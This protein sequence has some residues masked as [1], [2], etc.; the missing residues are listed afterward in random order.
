MDEIQVLTLNA[1]RKKKYYVSA[2]QYI[3]KIKS[4]YNLAFSKTL[5]VVLYQS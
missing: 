4:T 5:R 3:L 2:A 1:F